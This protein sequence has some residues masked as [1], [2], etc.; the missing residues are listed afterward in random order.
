MMETH[1]P[2]TCEVPVPSLVP[3]Q[4]VTSC[5]TSGEHLVELLGVSAQS[6]RSNTSSA[7][8]QPSVC[9]TLQ[10]HPH[11]ILCQGTQCCQARTSLWMINVARTEEQELATMTTGSAP[12]CSATP[13]TT[14]D[15]TLSDLLQRGQSVET[16]KCVSMENV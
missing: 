4:M 2:A 12:N 13:T 14:Q 10:R 8:A 16:T 7:P 9:T 5:L 1:P 15:A 11:N 3:G 6:N